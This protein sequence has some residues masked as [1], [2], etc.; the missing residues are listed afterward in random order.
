MSINNDIITQIT[1]LLS[2]SLSLI[3]CHCSHALILLKGKKYFIEKR[4]LREKRH[5]AT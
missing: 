2:L 3:F 5:E 1:F 4:L